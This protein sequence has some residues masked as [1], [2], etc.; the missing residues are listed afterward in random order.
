MGEQP[1]LIIADVYRHAEL[2]ARERG[3]LM[4]EWRYVSELRQVQGLRGPGRYCW[5]HADESEPR[6]LRVRFQIMTYLES[7]GY[8]R[9]R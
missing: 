6:H 2:C 5:Y 7:V 9:V 4:R 3:L 1:L 8:E